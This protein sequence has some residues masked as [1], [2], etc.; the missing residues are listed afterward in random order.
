MLLNIRGTSGSGKTTI[1][2]GIMEKGTV[3]V[4]GD[5]PKKPDAYRVE[6]P[7]GPLFVIGSYENV[8]GGCDGIATQ[9]EICDRVRMFIP[10]GHVLMEGL[11]MSHS[12]SRYA[13]L[14]RELAATGV[15]SIWAFLDTPLEVCL[16][17]VRVRREERG[18]LKPLNTKNTSDK[19]HANRSTFA[20]FVGGKANDWKLVKGYPPAKLDA[21]WLDHTRAV[22]QVYEWLTS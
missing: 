1:V 13:M 8:C 12:F 10:H 15:P 11:L 7:C 21:R 9:D 2:R 14:D 4:L 16:N 3:A 18:N 17:R 6:L 22:E 5:N 20:K 19:W